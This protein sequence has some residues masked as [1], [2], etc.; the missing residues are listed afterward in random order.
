MLKR[1]QLLLV[2]G[3]CLA[4]AGT[5][6]GQ[7]EDPLSRLV[8]EITDATT[9]E[10]TEARV[11]L[12]N[13]N[14]EAAEI[15]AVGIGVM[16]GRFDRAEGYAFQPDGAFYVDGGFEI[17]VVPGSYRLTISK[18]F[19]YLAKDIELE[20]TPGGNTTKR[21]ALERWINMPERGWY[22]ADD[23]IHIRRSPRENPYILTWIAAEDVHVGAMLRMGDFWSTYY[24]QYAFG[25]EGVFEDDGRVLTPGQEEPRTHEIG[26]TISLLADDTARFQKEYYF[27]DRVFDRVH[28]LNGL[29]GYAHQGMSFHGYRGMTMDVLRNKL[30]FLELLQFCVAEGPVH[31]EHYYFFLDL[32]FKLTATAGSDFPWCGEWPNEEN[33]VTGR[34]AQIGNARFYTHVG[35]AFSFEGWKENFKAGRTFV[36]SGPMLELRVNGALPGDTVQVSKGDTLRISAKAFGHSDRVPLQK[37]ELIG[38]SRV[39]KSVSIKDQGQSSEEL[40][41]DMEFPAEHG[42]WIAARSTAGKYQSAHTTPVYVSVDGGGFHNA[43]TAAANLDQCERYLKEIEEE[44]AEPDDRIEYHAWRYQDGLHERVA[45][46]RDIISQLRRDLK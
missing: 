19:E 21:L 38:H 35:D 17:E 28:E 43:I 42:I 29:T 4:L 11:R 30:D 27:Y 34:F 3:T 16:Y 13:V 7:A 1:I 33:D 20:L 41:I 6:F 15:P 14:D 5:T 37:L 8:V 46:T 39:L 36:S 44:V 24:E 32:G 12:I 18:G 26:H 45:E 23:H 9:G 40:V 22:S 10:P 31:S 25:D 2:G